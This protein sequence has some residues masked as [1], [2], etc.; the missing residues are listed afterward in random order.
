MTCEPVGSSVYDNVLPASFAW[1]NQ[2]SAVGTGGFKSFNKE[3]KLEGGEMA[4]LGNISDVKKDVMKEHQVELTP[5]LQHLLDN[6]SLDPGWHRT[7]ERLARGICPPKSLSTQLESWEKQLSVLEMALIAGTETRGLTPHKISKVIAHAWGREKGFQKLLPFQHCQR[8]G[9]VE[10][11]KRVD[12]GMSMSAEKRAAHNMKYE[13]NK[14]RKRKKLAVTSHED[15]LC[16]VATLPVPAIPELEPAMPEVVD[17]E[18]VDTSAVPFSECP[19][20]S[21]EGPTIEATDPS[22]EE[23]AV[24]I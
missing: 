13:V 8:R 2:G 20:E 1:K 23:M 6:E 5:I 15:E 7:N 10:R 12:A 3:I 4:E 22:I 21:M 16:V 18:Q 11:K 9:D 17:V 19:T 24:N 14:D